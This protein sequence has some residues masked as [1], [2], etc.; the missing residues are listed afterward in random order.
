ME[1]RDIFYTIGSV[2]LVLISI[3][4]IAIFYLAYRL[5]QALEA[6]VNNTKTVAET[7]GR[8]TLARMFLRVL[9]LIF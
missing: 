9:R 8:L 6:I 4:I 1:L 7:W 3:A 2:S 5:K